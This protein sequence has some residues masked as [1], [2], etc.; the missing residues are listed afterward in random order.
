VKV[1][2]ILKG[3]IRAISHFHAAF[4]EL[5]EALPGFEF[6][7]LES[8]APGEA[9]ALAQGACVDCDYLIAVGGDGTINEVLNGAMAA[10]GT[11]PPMGVLAYGTAND[12]ART[13]GL[14]GTATELTGLLAR[15]ARQ[16]VDVGRIQY[17]DADGEARQRWFLNAADVGIGA[18]VVR[19]LANRRQFVGSNLHYLRS[20]VGSLRS[21]RHRTLHV[22]TDRGLDWQGRSLALVAGNGRYFGSGLCVAPGARLD[23]G[24]LFVT[25]VGNASTWDFMRNIGRLKRGRLLEHPEAS[26]H[27]ACHIS[28]EHE[29]EA[30]RV[31]ADGELL[32]FTPV[33][34][35]VQPGALEFLMPAPA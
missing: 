19:H 31:E 4:R 22:R 3:D 21:Y 30:A 33:E 1:A 10:T 13:L 32:G 16:R 24:E 35:D 23:D 28:V 8:R 29:G 17:R 26:Y 25:L 7:L 15:D 34:I 27:Q 5:R 6:V 14:Q 9:T 18:E 20:I 2:L 11:T 12:L